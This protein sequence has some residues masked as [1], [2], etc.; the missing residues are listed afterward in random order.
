VPQ[1]SVEVFA[2]D[3]I[4][5]QSSVLDARR[6]E[7]TNC[8]QFTRLPGSSDGQT[9]CVEGLLQVKRARVQAI[10]DKGRRVEAES[11]RV[12]HPENIPLLLP[13]SS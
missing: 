6:D 4:A 8:H 7:S 1:T 9:S 12:W 5:D 10:N 13:C 11:V 2:T 3:R